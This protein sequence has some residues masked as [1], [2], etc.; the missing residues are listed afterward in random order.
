MVVLL[1]IATIGAKAQIAAYGMGSGGFLSSVTAQS[2][3]LTLTSDSFS[4]Y[5]GTFG[6]YDNTRHYGPIRFGVDGRGF[7]QK[8]SNSS[9]NGNQLRGGLVGA[10]LAFFSHLIPFSPYVQ[11]EVGAAS[12]NYGTQASRSTSLAYQVQGGVDYTV[13]PHL[14]VRLEYGIGQIGALYSGSRQEMQQV[15]L[16]L[17]VRL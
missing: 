16:G 12:T 11:A 13:V 14:D 6:I 1:S 7:I 4:A 9:A 2:G 17:V 5:G 8:S 3:P 15:G 10:R